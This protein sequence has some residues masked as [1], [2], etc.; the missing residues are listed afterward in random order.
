VLVAA[1]RPIARRVAVEIDE[2]PDLDDDLFPSGEA[3][4]EATSGGGVMRRLA[5]GSMPPGPFLV[6]DAIPEGFTTIGRF[7]VVPPQA[8]NFGADPARE[9]FR[10][11]QIADVYERGLD[12][13]VVE[14]GATLGGSPPFEPDPSS[15]TLDLGP[16][17]T[18]EVRYSAIGNQVRAQRA[19]GKYVQ[20]TGTLP[21]DELAAVL[22][23]LRE[24][25]G[26]ELVYADE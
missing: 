12:V 8:E 5:E 1:G 22:R 10:R 11:A 6:A 19:G 3:T 2:A 18:A 7:S 20:A 4:V 14:Q 26:G 24:V 25:P 16:L 9:G 23:S 13:L 21:P 15:P 17:G